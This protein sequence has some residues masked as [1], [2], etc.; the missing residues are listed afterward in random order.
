MGSNIRFLCV[1]LDEKVRFVRLMIALQARK[2][3]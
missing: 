2:L 3:G 1:A